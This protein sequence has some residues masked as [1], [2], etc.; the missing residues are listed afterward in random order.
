MNSFSITQLARFSGVKAHT[1]RMWEQRYHTLQPNRTEGNT[2]FYNNDQL[3]RLLNIVTLADVDY[4]VSELSKMP[5]KKLFKLLEELKNKSGDVHYEYFIPQLINAAINYDESAFEKT[6]SHCLLR[7]GFKDTYLLIIYPLLVRIG[8]LWSSDTIP[9]AHEHFISNLITQKLFTAIDS[10]PVPDPKS[11]SWLLFLPE[12]EF[13]EIG[14]LFASYLIRRAEIKVVYLG[15]N[16]P[17]ESLKMVLEN[18]SPENL[19]LFF[20]HRDLP[21][22]TREYLKHLGK[23]FK[24]KKIFVAG[25]KKFTEQLGEINKVQYLNS[26]EDLE[27]QLVHKT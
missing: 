14:L 9:P 22:D 25:H 6:F 11:E 3:K 2:R 16:L 23:L 27:K 1:I 18:I 13:H 26:I 12:Q 17:L 7:F 24:R 10:L 20:V 8:L 21:E 15:S 4:K 5:D 19:L